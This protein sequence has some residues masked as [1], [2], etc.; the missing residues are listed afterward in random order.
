MLISVILHPPQPTPAL[1]PSS[2]SHGCCRWPKQQ[3][4][5]RLTFPAWTQQN[6]RQNVPAGV[7][8]QLLRAQRS[9]L[10][11]LLVPCLH[12]GVLAWAACPSHQSPLCA[13]LT[14]LKVKAGFVVCGVSSVPSTMPGTVLRSLNIYEQMSEPIKEC[15]MLWERKKEKKREK[16]DAPIL[17]VEGERAEAS[18][19]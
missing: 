15:I 13:A 8:P 1:R 2:L 4:V 11:R 18:G 5:L 6:L 3:A 19:N 10:S 14:T 16:P 12:L 7:L 17:G 9:L